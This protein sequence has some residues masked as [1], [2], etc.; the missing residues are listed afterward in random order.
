[1]QILPQVSFDG[2]PP[3]DA[4]EARCREEID[5][6]Q[7]YHERIT[8]CRVVIGLPHRRHHKGNPF[9]IRIHVGVPGGE[10][11]VSREPAEQRSHED[12]VI[13]VRD[14]FD[15]ARRRLQDFVR[16]QDGR[17]KRHEG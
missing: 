4:L 12:P 2:I 15:A 3:S 9:S 5:K 11:E 6:L 13:A 10:I 17:V 14:A 1:M 8:S 16:R 7:R